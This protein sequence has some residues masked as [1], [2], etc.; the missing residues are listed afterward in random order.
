MPSTFGEFRDLLEEALLGRDHDKWC[1]LF[2]IY[3]SDTK[4]LAKDEKVY[5]AVQRRGGTA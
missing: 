3:R 5:R 4:E 1:R 2:D